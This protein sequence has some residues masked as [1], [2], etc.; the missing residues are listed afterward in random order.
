MINTNDYEDVACDRDV[1]FAILE[2]I[3]CLGTASLLKTKPEV[4]TVGHVLACFTEEEP[5]RIFI[6]RYIEACLCV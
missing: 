1:A 6:Q 5:A 4:A 2:Q 3:G